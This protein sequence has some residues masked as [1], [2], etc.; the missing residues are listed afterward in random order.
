MCTHPIDPMDIHLLGCAYGNECTK[1]HDVVYNTFVG[2]HM[3]WEQLH[4]FFNRVQLLSS[5]SQHYIH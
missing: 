3:E 4:A 1:T 2:F 5:T